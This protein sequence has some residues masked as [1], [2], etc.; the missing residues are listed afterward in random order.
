MKYKVSHRCNLKIS[1]S[2]IQ[3]I[4]KKQVKSI[5]IRYVVKPS[6]FFFFF[7]VF[8]L[9]R[10]APAV[11]G[12]SQA[13]GRIG[14]IAAGLHHSHSNLGYEQCLWPTPQLM[15]CWILNPVSKARDWTCV[16]MDPSQIHFFWAMTG[17][18][19]SVFL[20]YYLNM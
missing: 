6:I 16:L 19:N 1:S 14:A 7:F 10:A 5:S 17:T 8:C 12:N 2:H 20:K 9:F 11:Y 18:P 3:K 4:K 13:R 15:Q